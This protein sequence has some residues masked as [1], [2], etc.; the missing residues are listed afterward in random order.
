[1]DR[2]SVL[3]RI[4]GVVV[5]CCAWT[6]ILSLPARRYGGSGSVWFHAKSGGQ[7]QQ[8]CQSALALGKLAA[9]AEALSPL[10]GVSEPRR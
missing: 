7:N 5:G 4:G 2:R 10:A 6:G 1:M 8:N 9:W 3:R